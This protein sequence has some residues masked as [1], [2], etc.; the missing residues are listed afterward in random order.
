[1]L[2]F[3]ICVVLFLLQTVFEHLGSL[4]GVLITQVSSFVLKFMICVVVFHL[5]TVF[6]HLGSLPGVLITLGH[7]TDVDIYDLCGSVSPADSV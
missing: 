2:K 5:Q 3:M 1:M 6:E 4:P 7:I